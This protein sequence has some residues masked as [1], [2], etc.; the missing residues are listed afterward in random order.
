MHRLIQTRADAQQHARRHQFPR[1]VTRFGS[2]P[3]LKLATPDIRGNSSRR[4]PRPVGSGH[5]QSGTA[6]DA[7]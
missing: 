2:K 5:A 6:P 1:A 7:G 4:R 3:K